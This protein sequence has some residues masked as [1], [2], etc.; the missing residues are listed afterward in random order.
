MV[1]VRREEIGVLCVD[2]YTESAVRENAVLLRRLGEWE[3]EDGRKIFCSFGVATRIEG[4][5]QRLRL[6]LPSVEAF[7]QLLKKMGASLVGWKAR[8]VA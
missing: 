2:F 6:D 1:I 7:D 8:Q 3:D 4:Q 5:P